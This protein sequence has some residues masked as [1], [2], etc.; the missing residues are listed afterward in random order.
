MARTF[1]A[2]V[3]RAFPWNLHP[4]DEVRWNDPDEDV[5]SRD[6]VVL[7]VEYHGEIGD[8]ECIIRLTA[9]DGWFVECFA[10]ELS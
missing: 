1:A 3:R 8:P 2:D 10:G 7:S 5:C 9:A 4:G 6:V